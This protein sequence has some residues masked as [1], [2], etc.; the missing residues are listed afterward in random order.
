MSVKVELYGGPHD[1]VK[2]VLAHAEDHLKMVTALGKPYPLG[3][4]AGTDIASMKG[5]VSCYHL[6]RSFRGRWRYQYAGPA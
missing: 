6:R 1:G 5:E 2:M 3:Q 4:H